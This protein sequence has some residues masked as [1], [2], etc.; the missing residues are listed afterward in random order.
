MPVRE[1]SLNLDHE[2]S[3]IKR[4]SLNAEPF[5]RSRIIV[6]GKSNCAASTSP[7]TP[8]SPA[9]G[10]SSAITEA[11]GWATNNCLFS[12]HEALQLYQGLLN[13]MVNP[14]ISNILPQPPEDA[15][16][17]GDGPIFS[18]NRVLYSFECRED[19][20]AEDDDGS[21]Y[22]FSSGSDG[23]EVVEG[24][25]SLYLSSEV[26]C[27]QTIL[28]GNYS[29]LHQP[30]GSVE[31]EEE[32]VP[33]L[34]EATNYRQGS[35]S[36][37][38]PEETISP[39]Y[40]RFSVET[41]SLL[42]SPAGTVITPS[43]NSPQRSGEF[44]ANCA[45]VENGAILIMERDFQPNV[46][47]VP[48]ARQAELTGN[49]R[50]LIVAHKSLQQRYLLQHQK[51]IILVL[52]KLYSTWWDKRYV[53]DERTQ[54]KYFAEEPPPPSFTNYIAPRRAGAVHSP[55]LALSTAYTSRRC[56]NLKDPMALQLQCGPCSGLEGVFRLFFSPDAPQSEAERMQYF[57]EHLDYQIQAYRVQAYHFFFD[58]LYTRIVAVPALC[59]LQHQARLIICMKRDLFIREMIELF[60]KTSPARTT[61]SAF[62][63]EWSAIR[64]RLD[65]W[66]GASAK[67][68]TKLVA[69]KTAEDEHVKPDRR[70]RQISYLDHS[71]RSVKAPLNSTPSNAVAH[72]A[73]TSLTSKGRAAAPR[74]CS[75]T[76]LPLIKK[77]TIRAT[78]RVYSKPRAR[79]PPGR[80]NESHFFRIHSPETHRTG[81]N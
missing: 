80:I 53:L 36:P 24:Q 57:N 67:A 50:N 21:S 79:T 41:G 33:I 5:Q 78:E 61:C 43:Q 72:E 27:P 4:E 12:G 18:R 19:E 30:E 66:Y 3:P 62:D 49:G 16:R 31:E 69:S 42:S 37:R 32:E 70:K 25:V 20:G 35:P 55:L 58:Y 7:C 10:S 63:Q 15:G 52:S 45:P 9:S 81:N 59:S 71:N 8:E 2:Q 23:K 73:A 54:I 1:S 13:N 17:L 38:V 47:I 22:C 56:V 74:R 60:V 68:A 26:N 77:K 48:K 29:P 34:Y 6:H 11:E 46:Q 39:A 75:S 28:A 14:S 64:A 44:K 51:Y 65:S 76:Q 40:K